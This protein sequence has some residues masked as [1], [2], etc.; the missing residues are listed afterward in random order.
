ML[1]E[2]LWTATVPLEFNNAVV[3]LLLTKAYLH[4]NELTA[5][6]QIIQFPTR[7]SVATVAILAT[8]FPKRAEISV[9]PTVKLI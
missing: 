3:K 5:F 8:K 9:I 6:N 7:V 2:S 4:P 1:N